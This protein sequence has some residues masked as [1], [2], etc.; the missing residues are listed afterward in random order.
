MLALGY[1][2]DCKIGRTANLMLRSENLFPKPCAHEMRAA[3]RFLNLRQFSLKGP[4]RAADRFVFIFNML[5]IA[6]PSTN[7]LTFIS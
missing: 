2:F 7:L 4:G 3:K 5:L 6:K 1:R